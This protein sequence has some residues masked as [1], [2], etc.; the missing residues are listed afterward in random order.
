MT[1]TI[2]ARPET[3]RA[4]LNPATGSTQLR[5]FDLS[6][7]AL[8]AWQRSTDHT[9]VW[10]RAGAGRVRADF[11]EQDFGPGAAL[12]FAP[13]QPFALIAHAP[14]DG[15]V[16]QFASDFY[17]IERQR[18]DISCS[19]VLFSN[20]YDGPGIALKEA[21]QAEFAALIGAFCT[22][23]AH[24]P[25]PDPV[26][27]L[28]YLRIL[29]IR[30]TRIKQA[31]VQGRAQTRADSGH[32][33]MRALPDLIEAHYRDL[34]RPADYADRLSLSPKTVNRLVRAHFGKTLTQMIHERIVLEAKRELI[35]TDKLIR[36]IAL[37]LGY[38]DEYYFS[39]LFRK[40][41]GLSPEQFRRAYRQQ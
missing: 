23:L 17:C 28:S 2:D 41:T 32:Y 12:F 11:G 40:I 38:D 19:G 37:E 20:I 24:L 8:N 22:E 1:A 31:Q 27:L 9:I 33:A 18:H 26:L 16:M 35:V 10:I 36:Q 15:V 34:K 25:A 4:L 5:L 6:G 29:L 3:R 14:L 21:D 7:F 13:Y 30:C 39:R